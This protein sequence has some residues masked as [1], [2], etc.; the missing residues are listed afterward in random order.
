[1][2][3]IF[4]LADRSCQC[5]PFHDS[6]ACRQLCCDTPGRPPIRAGRLRSA[7]GRP[8]N[9]HATW[10][11][12]GTPPDAIVALIPGRLRRCRRV[13]PRAMKSARSAGS[14]MGSRADGVC[15]APSDANVRSKA[16]RSRSISRQLRADRC[17]VRTNTL[18]TTGTTPESGQFGDLLTNETARRA[19]WL[20]VRQA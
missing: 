3:A 18:G 7:I 8:L 17:N 14:A 19:Q 6:T 10:V 15:P 12:G 11:H 4:C 13:G 1:M 5:F 9:A 16:F 2:W 20:L